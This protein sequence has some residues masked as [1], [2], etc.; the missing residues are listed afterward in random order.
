MGSLDALGHDVEFR[1]GSPPL[2]IRLKSGGG[3]VRGKVEAC[4]AAQIVLVPVNT[5]LRPLTRF[6]R[7]DATGRYEISSVRPG[8]YNIAVARDAISVALPISYIPDA[9]LMESATRV[10]V[11][12]GETVGVDLKPGRPRDQ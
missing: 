5:A 12:D 9:R 3:T 8:D 7:C 1:A 2:E 6:G 10:T 11:H 4:Q